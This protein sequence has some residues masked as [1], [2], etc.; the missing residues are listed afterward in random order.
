MFKEEIIQLLKKQTKLSNEEL[1]K[2]VEVPPNTDL[3][4]YAF[5]CFILTKPGLHDKMWENVEKDFFNKKDPTSIA[6]HLSEEIKPTGNIEK[7]Q[8]TGPYVNFFINKQELTKNIIKIKDNYG[9]SNQSGKI[10]IEF[11]Q[12]NTHKAFH[13]GHIRGTSLGE[14]L[15]RIYEMLGKKVVRVN[16]SGDTGMHIAKWIWCYL[17]Y[18]S[19]EKLSNN[20]EWIA[21]IYVDAVKRLTKNEKFQEKVNEINKKLEEKSDKKINELWKKTRTLSI[22][23]WDKIYN[24]LGTHFDRHYFESEVEESGKKISE[25]LLKKGIAKESDGAVIINLEPYKLGVWVLLRND[26]TVLY[27][28]KDIALAQHKINEQD[29]D[30]FLIISG[31]EQNLHFR[32]LF[33][34]LELMKNKKKDKFRHLG[35]GMVRLPHGKMSSRTGDNILYSNFKEGVEEFAKKGIKKKWPKISKKELEDRAL[36]IAMGS[37]KYSILGQDPNK[38]IIFDKEKALRFEGDTGPYL[39]YTYARASSI[40]KKAKSGK[41]TQNK[42]KIDK[43][44]PSEIR[45]IKQIDIFPEIIQRAGKTMNPSLIANYSHEL[46]QSFNEFYHNCKVVG[47]KEEVFRLKLINSFRI[48]LKNSL[49]LLGIDVMEEM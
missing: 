49:Y 15:A 34:T 20:E 7:I 45:L 32:Q 18:H 22:K 16:Y 24:E 43:L 41:S 47:S 44:T 26:G 5:P 39:Q 3:G 9:K 14:S 48:T 8:A 38:T 1:A 29:L 28:A 17:N 31:D 6:R 21:G 13:V 25:N 23:S 36:K 10:M 46:A 40:I 35:F 42:I 11:S 19:K 12:P 37:I 33:K 4:D 30:E 2:L 27:S